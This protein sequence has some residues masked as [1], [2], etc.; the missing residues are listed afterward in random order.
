MEP[1]LESSTLDRIY[2][3]VSPRRD[4][5]DVGVN[6]ELHRVNAADRALVRISVDRATAR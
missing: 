4:F 2:A 3:S 5:F 6:D 1:S